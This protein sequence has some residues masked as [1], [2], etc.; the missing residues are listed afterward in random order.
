MPRKV[1]LVRDVIM[2]AVITKPDTLEKL[3]IL[4]RYPQYDLACAGGTTRPE[5]H[6]KRGVD[7]RWIYPVTLPNGGTSV[8]FKTLLSNVC[9]NDCKYCPLRRQQDVRRCT[10]TVEETCRVF[11][12]YYR[13]REVFGLFLSSGVIGT[14]ERTM[15]LLNGIAARLRKTYQFRG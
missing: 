5:E 14:P 1:P 4:S 10:L 11:L 15:A 9:S 12:D 7:G 13:K 6:R 2:T 3:R 8:L